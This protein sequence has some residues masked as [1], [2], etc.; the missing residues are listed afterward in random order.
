MEDFALLLSAPTNPVALLC[1]GLVYFIVVVEFLFFYRYTLTKR[2]RDT[3]CSVQLTAHTAAAQTNARCVSSWNPTQVARS[4]ARPLARSLSQGRSSSGLSAEMQSGS[5]F[6]CWFVCLV[7][8]V[9]LAS[10]ACFS[11]QVPPV[12]PSSS[13]LPRTTAVVVT[14][15]LFFF[16]CFSYHISHQQSQSVCLCVCL[17]VCLSRPPCLLCYF[18]SLLEIT[19]NSRRVSA[20]W[21]LPISITFRPPTLC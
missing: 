21:T 15:G 14:F 6:I 4:L 7:W 13:M 8:F 5:I 2:H 19:T 10:A 20:P 3:L 18:C 11:S 9:L 17:F 12:S 1:H 16:V